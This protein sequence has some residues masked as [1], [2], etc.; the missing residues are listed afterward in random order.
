VQEQTRDV[1]KTLSAAAVVGVTLSLVLLPS[2]WKILKK[3]KKIEM[4]DG[5]LGATRYFHNNYTV[6]RRKKTGA[7]LQLAVYI[8][9]VS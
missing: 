2:A 8:I 3:K 9:A 4:D 5:G 1:R 6:T 7:V